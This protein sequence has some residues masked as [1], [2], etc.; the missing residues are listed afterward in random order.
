MVASYYKTATEY[1]GDQIRASSFFGE[2]SIIKSNPYAPKARLDTTSSISINIDRLQPYYLAGIT[3]TDLYKF[4][5][6]TLGKVINGYSLT[7]VKQKRIT[8]LNGFPALLV[9]HEETSQIEKDYIRKDVYYNYLLLKDKK[10][11]KITFWF[12]IDHGHVMPAG[13]YR[14]FKSFRFCPNCF[15]SRK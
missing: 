4:D 2:D 9:V 13:A 3:L 1:M 12:R 10:I 6:V 7:N 11:F 15:T 8:K 14:C 5:N